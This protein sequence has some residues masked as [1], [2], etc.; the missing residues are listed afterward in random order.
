MKRAVP[1]RIVLVQPPAGVDFGLQQGHGNDY[2]T[3]QRQRSG[4]SDLHFDFTLDLKNE[5]KS[6]PPTFV[7]PFAQGPPAD[8]FVYL[9]IGACAGQ[10]GTHWSRRL[11]IPLKSITWKM[12]DGLRDG[13]VLE[14]RVAGTGK[15]GGPS[16][17]TARPFAGWSVALTTPAAATTRPA[18]ARRRS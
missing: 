5:L 15:D 9:D 18:S 10:S 4:S 14:T 8:R 11:K 7:G 16:C 3:V 17:G 1:C 13:A 6:A 12:I 2:E